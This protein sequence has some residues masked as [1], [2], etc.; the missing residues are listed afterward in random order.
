MSKI[1][2]EPALS[3]NAGGAGVF[4]AGF[5][6]YSYRENSNLILYDSSVP[7]KLYL[8]KGL[9]QYTYEIFSTTER[10]RKYEGNTLG[11]VFGWLLTRNDVSVSAKASYLNGMESV[12]DI[13]YNKPHYRGKYYTDSWRGK[14]GFLYDPANWGLHVSA[15]Y[16][17]SRGSGRE[18]VQ[19]FN[20]SSDVNAWVTDSEIPARYVSVNHDV[21]AVAIVVDDEQTVDDQ[22][23][24]NG[25][26]SDR[27]RDGMQLD[28]VGDADGDDAEEEQH[29][30]VAQAQV[31]QVG[32]VEKAKGYAADADQNHFKAAEDDKGQTY[33]T[34]HACGQGDGTLHGIERHPALGAGTQR[35]ETG[36]AVVV[37]MGIVEEVVDEIGVDLHDQCKQQAQGCRQPVEDIV[38]IGLGID[39]RQGATYHDG[40]G[41]TGEGLG[42]DCQQ[43]GLPGVLF[44]ILFVHYMFFCL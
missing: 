22:S 17:G 30:D 1:G 40:Y 37:A 23:A 34:R 44:D 26:Y 5:T 12:F 31:G 16:N 8:L 6:Y 19:Y 36:G 25:R 20:S 21:D 41:G 28:I 42:T 15:D 35:T 39:M 3:F 2:L 9:G 24:G 13:D 38:A 14:F 11:A 27:R 18:L 4:S 29:E 43:P 32:G 10:E 7:Q 33:H